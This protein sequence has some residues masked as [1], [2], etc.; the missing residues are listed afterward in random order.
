MSVPSA[1]QQLVDA[2][3]QLPS[4]GPNAAERISDYLVRSQSIAKLQEALTLAQSLKLCECCQT[5]T[6]GELCQ[7]C[8]Q[9]LASEPSQKLL[10][11]ESF[12]HYQQAIK[13]GFNGIVFVLHGL[14]SPIAGIGPK[15]L[16]LAKLQA[17]VV[18]QSFSDIT[19]ALA[20]SAEGRTTQ[21]YLQTLLSSAAAV[22]CLSFEQWQAKFI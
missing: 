21:Q 4:I 8:Q 19:L 7:Q 11:V 15:E 10:V 14:L 1:Y 5:F 22:H 6:D 12:Q 20:N 18:Q 16:N 17:L 9:V 2:L 13:Q 3:D